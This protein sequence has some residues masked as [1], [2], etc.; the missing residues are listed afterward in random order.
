[1]RVE[2]HKICNL[3]DELVAQWRALQALTPEFM[4]PLFG[5]DFA[6]LV[7]KH[8]IDAKVAI[9]FDGDQAIAFFAFHPAHAG[10]ARAI[11]APFSDYQG[12]VSDPNAKISGVEFL[13]QAG[14]TSI[15]C[16]SLSDPHGI[17][18]TH[19]MEAVETYRIDCFDDGPA[20]MESLRVANPK[21]AKNLRRLG[22]KMEREL[23]PIRLVGH[24]TEQSSFDALNAIKVAQ[25]H[26]TG[27][28]NVLRPKW[29]QGL[30]QDLFENQIGDFGGCLVSLY[31]GEKF[32]AGQ[33]GVR[34]GNWFHP[35]I[36]STCPLSHPYSPGIVFLSEM[37]KASTSLG[38]RVIDLSGGHAHYK[39]QFCRTPYTAKAGP[40]GAKPENA[41]SQQSGPR[42]MIARR[43]DLIGAV[44]PDLWGRASAI[45]S[46]IVAVPRRLAARNNP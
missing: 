19:Q 42:A 24:D 38:L 31:A 43:L 2:V 4:T 27:I 8:R 17:F 21:W 44:E 11:G 1:V 14:I 37:V 35:W 40:I 7:A 32:V 41:P 12:I 15:L 29:V 3:S 45:G 26:E 9:G 39:A 5:P 25:F 23:G 16:T 36:A 28:T 30:M 13:N 46:A 22:N 20:Q 18:D 6:T 10:Y 34:L 33:F